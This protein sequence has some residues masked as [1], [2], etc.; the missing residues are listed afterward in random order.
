MA[1]PSS[2]PKIFWGSCT[3]WALISTSAPVFGDNYFGMDVDWSTSI[4]VLVCIILDRRWWRGW[5]GW[6][7]W[8]ALLP[9]SVAPQRDL[10]YNF[11]L[12]LYMAQTLDLCHQIFQVM[13]D[14][15]AFKVSVITC[16]DI[17]SSFWYPSSLKIQYLWIS[18]GNFCIVNTI[19]TGSLYWVCI[20]QHTWWKLA[21]RLLIKGLEKNILLERL[22]RI[23]ML[24]FR[25]GFIA[26]KFI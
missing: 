24:E 18:L 26:R 2:H 7:G 4:F 19:M 20:L 12:S 1:M 6:W 17:S 22:Q 16:T 25:W 11:Y 10:R 23:F 21:L 15:Y 3:E 9:R 5:W 13:H 14:L 8:W